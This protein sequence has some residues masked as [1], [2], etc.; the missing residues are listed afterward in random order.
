L[1]DYSFTSAPQLKRDPLGAPPNLQV[2]SDLPGLGLPLRSSVTVWK[3]ERPID[4][5]AVL[6]AIERELQ[7]WYGAESE[8]SESGLH[9]KLP[10]VR[11]GRRSLHDWM[12]GPTFGNARYLEVTIDETDRAFHLVVSARTSSLVPLLTTVSAS[13]VA[14]GAHA[15]ALLAPLIGGVAGLVAW[16]SEWWTFNIG[17]VALRARCDAALG[18]G[19]RLTSA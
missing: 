14:V 17:V 15:S 6:T 13:G 8:R 12:Y 3:K 4:T 18:A 19:G 9:A 11:R 7:S 16:G 2:M 1:N 5:E 10:L